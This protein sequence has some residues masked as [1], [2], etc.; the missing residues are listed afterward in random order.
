R[1][2]EVV[3]GPGDDA[4]ATI[5][6][7]DTGVDGLVCARWTV[8]DGF[9]SAPTA[10]HVHSGPAGATG[11][12]VLTIPGPDSTAGTDRTTCAAGLDPATVRAVFADPSAHHVD[13]HSAGHPDGAARGQLDRFAVALGTELAA[14]E[15]VGGSGVSGASGDATVEVLRDGTTL[16]A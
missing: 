5:E 7:I 13:V 8:A 9:G 15:V 12:V 1:G 10:A 14:G 6:L 4:E 11:P 16:C 3:P 2:S